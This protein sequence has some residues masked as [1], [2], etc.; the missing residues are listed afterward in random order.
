M[1]E[2]DDMNILGIETSGAAGSIALIRAGELFGECSLSASGRRH[3]R[4]LVPEIS[5]L[6]EQAG[7]RPTDLNVIAVSIGPGSFTGLRVGVVCAKTLA[8]AVGCQLVSV[9]TFLAVATSHP[10]AAAPVWVIDNALRGDVCAAEYR[11]DSSGWTC[12]IPAKL[13]SLE[14]WK[15]DVTDQAL[16]TGPGVL[17]LQDELTGLRLGPEA[18]QVPQAKAIA[19]LGA[20]RARQGLLADLWTLAPF[21]MRRSAA[22]EKAD[23]AGATDG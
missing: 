21:Y 19:E 17:P 23:A 14:D 18:L 1:L 4:T 6:L 13:R 22:E 20:Q 10:P 9:D 15:L 2:T 8:Y 16:V 7:L 5:T 11:H 12:T 3:A